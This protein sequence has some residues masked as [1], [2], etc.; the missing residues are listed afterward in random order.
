MIGGSKD[1]PG[2]QTGAIPKERTEKAH[3]KK[4]LTS[5]TRDVSCFYFESSFGFGKRAAR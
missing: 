5:R 1:H 3:L 2:L 4:Q